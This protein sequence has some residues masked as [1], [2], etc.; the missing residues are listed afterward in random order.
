[1]QNKEKIMFNFKN[2]F[3]KKKVTV[4][5]DIVTSLVPIT[6][7]KQK[8]IDGLIKDYLVFSKSSDSYFVKLV[9]LHHKINMYVKTPKSMDDFDTVTNMLLDYDRYI[10]ESL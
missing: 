5:K 6:E 10:N 2:L 3:R 4:K 7:T 8:L 9:L 1:M